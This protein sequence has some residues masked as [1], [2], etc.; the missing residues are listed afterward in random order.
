MI[1]EAI[2][3]IFTP[4]TPLAKKYGFLYHSISL[5]HRYERCE[6]VWLPHLKNCQDIFL[7]TIQDLPQKKSVVV[8]G[9]A[10]LHEIP[11]HL[12]AN[13]FESITLVDVVHP[14][15]HHWAAK[16]NSRLKLVTLDLGGSLAELEK[17]K[18]LQD[19]KNLIQ[20]LSQK[21]LF[22]FEADLIVSGNLLSQLA[23]L[24]M[25]ALE[26]YTSKNLILEEKDEI[27]TAYGEIHLK[28]LR[29]CKGR[30]L[31]YTDR[32]VTYRDPEGKV[33]YTGSYPVH[34]DGF[35]KIKDWN[36]MLAP[37][38]EASKD[39]SIEMNVEAYISNEG[40]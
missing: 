21:E 11:L 37:L 20:D 9:S 34:F 18:S 7:Q 6:K 8:L 3:M 5:K 36:W 23:L 39:Y 25:E 30:K 40:R 19:L 2:E 1:R 14:L 29:A 26:K 12:L 38:K 10:H 31:V 17:L 4:A 28:N 33:T 22:H 13:N 35:T 15:K 27:C 16:R 32:A 24:P